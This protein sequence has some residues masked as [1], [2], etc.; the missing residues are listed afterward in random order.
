M[1]AAVMKAGKAYAKRRRIEDGLTT[2]TAIAAWDVADIAQAQVLL[3]E[4]YSLNIDYAIVSKVEDR[5]TYRAPAGR[6]ISIQ[7]SYA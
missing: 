1:T 5:L 6:I 7:R 4:A 3:G 2:L